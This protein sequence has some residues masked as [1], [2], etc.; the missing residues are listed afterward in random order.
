[1]VLRYRYR[2][3]MCVITT[4]V[5]R[6]L[7]RTKTNSTTN[8]TKPKNISTSKLSIWLLHHESPGCMCLFIVSNAHNT[9]GEKAEKALHI[10]YTEWWTN[11]IR[12]KMKLALHKPWRLLC[13]GD[14]QVKIFF[15]G[16][17]Y[18]SFEMQLDIFTSL[19]LSKSK[20]SKF[21]RENGL[22]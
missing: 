11:A 21:T 4:K 10:S 7:T 12:S 16:N 22:G 8:Q 13:F 1:M 17:N 19:W 5:E 18:I 15:F 2:H 6:S 14:N 3:V 9:R 20:P